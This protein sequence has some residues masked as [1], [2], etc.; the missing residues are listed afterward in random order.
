MGRDLLQGGDWVLIVLVVLG[1]FPELAA[2][3]QFLLV[4][5]HF[6]RNHYRACAPVFPRTAILIPAW[7]EAAVIGTSIDRLMALQYPR[8]ALRIFLVDDASTDETPAVAVAKAAQYPGHVVHLRR[9]KGGQGKAHTL[10]YGLDVIL[11]DEWMEALLITD[12]D[13]IFEADSLR[14]MTRHL[15]DPQVG[16]VTAY[17][18]EGSRPGNYMTRF[19]GYEYVTAQAAARRGQNVLGVMACLAGGAQLHTR[20]NLLALGGRIDTTSLAEDTFTTFQTQLNGRRVVFEPHARVW[21]EEPGSVI[22]LW[23]QRLRWA[24]GNVQV[25][26]RYRKLW[27]R[28]SRAHRLGG[29]SFGVFWFC[30]FLQPVFMITSSASL[31]TLYFAHF[32][33]AWLA[34]HLLW[35]IN[36]VTYIFITGF[37]LLIDPQTARHTW[38]QAAVFPGAVNLAIVLYTCFPRLFRDAIHRVLTA[39]HMAPAHG[40]RA[41]VILVIYAWPAASMALAY[42]AKVAEPH[43]FGR[44]ISPLVVYTVGYGSL[45]CACTFASYVKEL[46][47]AE[48]TWDKTEK[49]GKMVVPT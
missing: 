20:A 2:S 6:W 41:G 23:K 30:L 31:L 42:L 36:A 13:V 10:N 35:I 12:A 49:T 3:W 48:M 22:G 1:A 43:R 39:G 18:K 34:F 37:A 15:A 9:S 47:G 16:A 19:I 4:A 5:G 45:L 38:L 44:F 8:E 25:T 28:P 40:Y 24:R 14:K 26:R 21:A 11:A 27:F 17:I 7:N 29:V 46:R 32:P 33:R